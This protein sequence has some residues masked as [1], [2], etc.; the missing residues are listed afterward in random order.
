MSIVSVL[1]LFSCRTHTHTQRERERERHGTAAPQDIS[2]LT[3]DAPLWHPKQDVWYIVSC[4]PHRSFYS[5]CVYTLTAY[6]EVFI[7]VVVLRPADHSIYQFTGAAPVTS[8]QIRTRNNMYAHRHARA[9][10]QSWHEHIKIMFTS[11]FQ[12]TETPNT[13]R[14]NA[15]GSS[16]RSL[17]PIIIIL[18]Y[19]TH[20]STP[21]LSLPLVS[22]TLT[23]VEH[24]VHG[25][26]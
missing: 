7:A 9:T 22:H 15:A 4:I 10:Y 8:E 2:R 25:R 13:R 6:L 14:E 16:G 21:S 19:L 11:K 17:F 20:T 23:H 5:V 12:H 24:S 26:L 18:P 1:F 3:K